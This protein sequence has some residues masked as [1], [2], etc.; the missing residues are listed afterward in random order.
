MAW[1]FILMSSEKFFLNKE[2]SMTENQEKSQ[3]SS[4]MHDCMLAAI[5]ASKCIDF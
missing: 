5:I 3:A 1:I 2:F 4:Y